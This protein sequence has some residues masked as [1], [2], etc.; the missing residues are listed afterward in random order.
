MVLSGTQVF[1][2]DS[3]WFGDR[4]C[5]VS[6]FWRCLNNWDAV[7][8]KSMDMLFED[9]SISV[10]SICDR[11]DCRVLELIPHPIISTKIAILGS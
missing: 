1:S 9:R 8:H 2:A 7:I 3:A 11:H 6:R 10:L 4:S 5:I